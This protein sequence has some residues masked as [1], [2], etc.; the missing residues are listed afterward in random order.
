L[1]GTL[2]AARDN[3]PEKKSNGSQFYF[4]LADL[5]N[6]DGE[7][8]VFGKIVQGMDI[9]DEMGSVKTDRRDNPREAIIILNTEVI[10][11]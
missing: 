11:K 8:T 1:R 7:Y 2:A 6:L 5:P 4:C 9:V 3:N 10:R